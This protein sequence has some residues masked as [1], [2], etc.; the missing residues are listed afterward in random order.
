MGSRAPA[1]AVR[2]GRA[3]LIPG[4]VRRIDL[5]TASAVSRHPTGRVLDVDLALVERSRSACSP[6]SNAAGRSRGA[7]AG[8]PAR[9]PRGG[10]ALADLGACRRASQRRV[11]SATAATPPGTRR[12]VSSRAGC[13][14]GS[15]R[16]RAPA[17]PPR[18]R[19]RTTPRGPAPGRQAPSSA[20]SR[21]TPRGT[22]GS[23]TSASPGGR[24]G[25]VATASA[26][27]ARARADLEYAGTAPARPDGHGRPR[28]A[29]AYA[30]PARRP[31]VRPLRLSERRSWSF[32]PPCSGSLPWG[33]LPSDRARR[34]PWPRRRPPLGHGRPSPRVRAARASR[35]MRD[36]DCGW[37]RP[38]RRRW[39][40]CGPARAS[41][42]VRRRSPPPGGRA[43]VG[44]CRR[45]R[46]PRDARAAALDE[47]VGGWRAARS[48]PTS[49]TRPRAWL[50]TSSSRPASG[51][52]DGP[53]GRRDV[54]ADQRPP[55]ARLAHG[56]DGVLDSRRRLRRGHGPVRPGA[57]LRGRLG[58]GHPGRRDR[59][60]RPRPV[61]LLG[62]AWADPRA[63][64]AG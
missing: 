14:R 4:A 26:L 11:S 61:R 45:R 9:G 31:P 41:A 55:R 42:W 49:W 29:D 36:R 43:A 3:G 44:A 10:D 38:R 54:G 27:L 34:S 24:P 2:A 37:P 32:R 47:L 63:S 16:P 53:S 48:S 30:R 64:A 28:L 18:R 58:A 62:A 60:R 50:R 21:R 15:G 5:Q 1:P 51:A 25:P 13:A 40:S 12:S 7:S 35:C 23:S 20:T 33:L 8:R 6:P 52:G 56:V 39:G 17:G 22:P 57:R 59:R 19:L 46:R